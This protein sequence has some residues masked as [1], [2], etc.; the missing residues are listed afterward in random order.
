MIH[1]YSCSSFSSSHHSTAMESSREPAAAIFLYLMSAS[2]SLCGAYCDATI[3]MAQLPTTAKICAC[4]P[5][6]ALCVRSSLVCWPVPFLFF[7]IASVL[8]QG[9]SVVWDWFTP[10][11]RA[12]CR[13][14]P[15]RTCPSTST[16]SSSGRASSCSSSAS[17]SAA[18]SSGKREQ[19]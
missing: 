4:V 19:F 18:T 11:S 9:A 13:P 1:P 12:Q 17:S 10:T 6:C 8:V 2:V 5:V 16:W 14:S 15:S 3:E 7:I